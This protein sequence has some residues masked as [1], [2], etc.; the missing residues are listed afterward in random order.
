MGEKERIEQL[1]NALG[2]TAEMSLVFYRSAPNAGASNQEAMKLAQAYIAAIL[3]N[4]N[5]EKPETEE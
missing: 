4:Q 5:K 1:R 2:I 3:F